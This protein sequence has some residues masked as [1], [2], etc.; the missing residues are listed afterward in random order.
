MALDNGSNHLKLSSS[1]KDPLTCDYSP[2]KGTQLQEELQ[3]LRKAILKLPDS[4]R[5]LIHWLNY[6]LLSF[7]E[8]A[9]NLNCSP[10]EAC[11]SWLSAIEHLE[12]RYSQND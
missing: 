6:K 1:T 2:S 4:D 5:Q 8:I 9:K 10:D 12:L 3:N 7:A 11:R